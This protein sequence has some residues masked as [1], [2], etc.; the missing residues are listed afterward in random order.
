MTPI[1]GRD[2]Y[3]ISTKRIARIA[4]QLSALPLE[5]I[6]PVLVELP[7]HHILQLQ[8]ASTAGAA[9]H[10]AMRISP[11]WAWLFQHHD[12]RLEALWIAA[13]RL[14]MTW[15]GRDLTQTTAAKQWSESSVKLQSWAAISKPEDPASYVLEVLE[16]H[17]TIS[18]M[19]FLGDARPVQPVYPYF[20]VFH[21]AP[22]GHGLKRA[23]RRAACMYL[24][25]TLLSSLIK[26]K[27]LP[28]SFGKMQT[29]IFSASENMSAPPSLD[30]L[31]QAADAL[32]THEWTF[33]DVML[34]LPWLL[35]ALKLLRK[36]KS[37]ELILL[38]ELFD[39]FPE[40]LKM[41]LAPQLMEPNRR[42]P[43]IARNLRLDARKAA[44]LPI[45]TR[46]QK[47]QYFCQ[48]LF[49]GRSWFRFR[50]AH[51][52]LVPYN[53]CFDLFSKFKD[54]YD[55]AKNDPTISPEMLQFFNIANL[56]FNDVYSYSSSSMSRVAIMNGQTCFVF[57]PDQNV[58]LP[59]HPKEL[60]WLNAFIKCVNWLRFQFPDEYQASYTD[61]LGSSGLRYSKSAS[62]AT[63]D[64]VDYEEFVHRA[65][66]SEIVTQ[67]QT[68]SRICDQINRKQQ[69]KQPSLLALYIPALSA[70]RKKELLA[71]MFPSRELG[72]ETRTLVFESVLQKVVSVLQSNP[73]SRD[74]SFSGDES[75]QVGASAEP[76]FR[77]GQRASAPQNKMTSHEELR[78]CE[79][80][81]EN[82]LLTKDDQD[83]SIHRVLSEVQSKIDQDR[84][85]NTDTEIPSFRHAPKP[86]RADTAVCY[87]CRLHRQES[88]AFLPA[89]CKACGDFN[90][91][92]S[93]M[94]L[95]RNLD[96]RGRT[97]LVTGGRVNL[98]FH[99]ALRLLRC[100][101]FV[102]VSSRY[103]ADAVMRY[104]READSGR[105]RN[106]LKIIGADFRSAADAMALAREVKTILAQNS[107]ILNILVNN[108]AQTLTD[109]KEAEATAITRERH[110]L[111]DSMGSLQA[112]WLQKTSYA[113]KL[114]G[115]HDSNNETASFTGL[116]GSQDIAPVKSATSVVPYSKSSWVQSLQEIP[117]ED[118]ISAHSVNTFVPLILIREL[119]PVMRQKQDPPPF[120]ERKRNPGERYGYIVNVSSRE[121][122]F[123]STK[124]HSAKK[125][126]HVHTNMS[127]A[128][129]NMITE[130][131]AAE[132]WKEYRVAM[133]TVDPGYMS[134]AP[135][136]ED[137]FNGERPIGWGDGAGRVLWPIAVGQKAFRSGKG[138]VIWGQFLKHYGAVRVEPGYGRG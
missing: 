93:R 26:K 1:S 47:T 115:S 33:Q 124:G 30:F 22:W 92:A 48:D 102:I 36:A 117:Y 4:A 133:N 25:A 132:A 87:I 90:L 19:A 44:H 38:A 65:P 2:E 68:D 17:F 31:D 88:H 128:A 96:L 85:P 37:D 58:A 35:N 7:L 74:C 56:G 24:P 43:H 122:I 112:L 50:H 136:F 42:Q 86:G 6:E 39:E 82:L 64:A 51:C 110:L 137:A 104:Q 129:L 57:R 111:G 52:C 105:W 84:E 72:P 77:E 103:P 127:K 120:T 116:L 95:P 11:T 46:L 28:E 54:T 9:L 20:H 67:L 130:T 16:E 91:S 98:G 107:S 55:P 125:G 94:S 10:D 61:A 138:K 76:P 80:I 27:R 89:L 23:D 131:E 97:A 59:A 3:P 113:P 21:G 123:E 45:R 13:N 109:S 14:S 71:Q 119:L 108:A 60:E 114:R 62:W 101:A 75:F 18:F 73:I 121:G 99:T 40:L 53:W 100:G 8:C 78:I 135:E 5:L 81:L 49:V 83:G 69:S 29:D 15:C 118:L 70:V 63:M 134:A 41:P 32:H 12:K 66:V 106:R 34:V 126:K 79:K